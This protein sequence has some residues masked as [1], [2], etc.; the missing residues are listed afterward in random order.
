M[1][2]S[3]AN[4]NRAV[5]QI[6]MADECEYFVKVDG[7]DEEAFIVESV[8][9]NRWN[10]AEVDYH[11]SLKVLA[12]T[13]IDPQSLLSKSAT[14]SF[15]WRG[16]LAPVHAVIQQVFDANGNGDYSGYQLSL[17]SPL[18]QLKHQQHNRVF[19][20]ESSLQIAKTILTDFVDGQYPVSLLANDVEPYPMTVQYQESD[21]DFV[22]RILLR[23][24]IMLHQ[25]QSVSS[26]EVLLFDDVAQ[27]PLSDDPIALPF[28]AAKGAAI[29]D[30]YVSLV[31]QSWRQQPQSVAIA[32]YQF[33]SSE[34][35]FAQNQLEGGLGA[36]H[37]RWG[38][39]VLN[40][41]AAKKLADGLA[42]AFQAQANTV[43]MHSNC[44]GLQPGMC[45][46]LTGHQQLSG[47]YLILQM[48]LSGN[49]SSATNSGVSALHKGYENIIIAIPAGQPY[50]P[51]YRAKK[52]L[53][54]SITATI[55]SEVDEAG[56]YR[57]RLPFDSRAESEEGSLPTR[58]LQPFGGADHGM[59]FP[60]TVGTE[61]ILSF[62]NGDID[63]PTILG[64][65]YND[66]SPNVVTN[67]NSY[68]NLIRTR[69]KHEFLLDDSPEAE[70]IQ[71]NTE[72]QKN[73]LVLDATKDQHLAQLHSEEGDIEIFA[74]KSMQAQSGADMTIE[75]GGNQEVTVKGDYSLMT[76]EGDITHQAGAN[77]SLTAQED[78]SWVTE[79]GKLSIEVGAQLIVEAA[80]G[81]STHVVAGDKTVVVEDGSYALEASENISFAA[82][83]AL[84]FS[85][86]GGAI[87]IDSSGNLTLDGK[88]IEMTAD[89]I[90]VKGGTV[91]NN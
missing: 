91:G 13:A 75:V 70:K 74:G 36:Q 17:V 33:P 18:W 34:A 10:L 29:D 84:T 2:Q 26:L 54:S 81:I 86:G 28:R 76:E 32:D 85:Q 40:N 27:L 61:V 22:H 31:K 41:E 63:R 43:V 15:L 35:V 16:V 89:K 6:G 14:V 64:A 46:E 45:I 53:A 77:L 11:I 57:I 42:R 7:F 55:A 50:L 12:L 21:W 23:D 58:L 48:E 39:N 1:I 82:G 37:F 38:D 25:H 72:A 49:Q 79:E 71:L 68:H 5:R 9:L 87:Q 66:Q 30:E 73:R 51:A 65:V 44:R 47:R 59:H 56:L 4:I 20:G 24:G 90:I 78:L 67:E 62:E 88:S 69:G 80:D 8:D 60:L 19:M 52:P 83:S 3:V